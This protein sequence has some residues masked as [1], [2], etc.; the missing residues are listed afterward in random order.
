MIGI[1]NELQQQITRS[2]K[3][4]VTEVLSYFLCQ[5]TDSRLN[6]ATLVM[7]GMIYLLACQQPFLISHLRKEYDCVGR[8]L[9]EDSSAF[10]IY[11]ASSNRWSRI[12]MYLVVDALDECEAGLPE[13]LY[14]IEQCLGLDDSHTRLSLELNAHHVSHAVDVY[15]DHKVSRLASLG[16]DKAL[17]E[18]F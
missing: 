13:L 7:K 16:N 3:S 15:V 11:P 12:R 10:Y 8:K 1:I 2:G 4:S 14:G 17:Q 18:K 5:G 6:T 9:F